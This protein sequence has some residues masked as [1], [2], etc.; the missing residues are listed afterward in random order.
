MTSSFG[1]PRSARQNDSCEEATRIYAFDCA[2]GGARALPSEPPIAPAVAVFQPNQ[3]GLRYQ[4]L[5]ALKD[6]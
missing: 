3:T 1:L 2:I 6:R 5:E 4:V